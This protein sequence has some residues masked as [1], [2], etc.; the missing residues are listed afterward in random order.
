MADKVQMA[1]E[2]LVPEMDILIQKNYFTKKDVK[3]IMKKRRYHEYQFEKTDVMPL[4]FFKAIKYE[5]VLNNRMKQQK[6]KF[7]H[8]KK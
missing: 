3:K 1:L 4:D 8:K 6:K 7:T 2:T 5:K